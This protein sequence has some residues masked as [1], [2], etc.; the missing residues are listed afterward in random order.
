MSDSFDIQ[1]EINRIRTEGQSYE[2]QPYEASFT[3]ESVTGRRETLVLRLTRIA[4]IRRLPDILGM[5]D[6]DIPAMT[7]GEIRRLIEEERRIV[8]ERLANR[9]HRPELQEGWATHVEEMPSAMGLVQQVIS[10]QLGEDRRWAR[11]GFEVE[12][13][14]TVYPYH[15][16]IDLRG[17]EALHRNGFEQLYYSKEGVRYDDKPEVYGEGL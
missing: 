9:R 17:V 15:V 14:Q 13:E 2:D 1:A 8:R 3:Q 5:R 11:Y 10:E 6:V 16:H 7:P 12:S 4:Y